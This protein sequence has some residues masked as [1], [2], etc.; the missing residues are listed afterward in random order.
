MTCLEDLL[1]IKSGKLT[2]ESVAFKLLI[3]TYLS[4]KYNKKI[5]PLEIFSTLVIIKTSFNICLSKINITSSSINIYTYMDKVNLRT[6]G[7]WFFFGGKKIL[8]YKDM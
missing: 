5:K 1:D 4:Q 7:R 8:L 3:N 2:A 6:I